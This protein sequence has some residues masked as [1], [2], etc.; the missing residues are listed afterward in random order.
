MAL[1]RAETAATATGTVTVTVTEMTVTEI[2]T[3][4]V[5]EIGA[6]FAAATA[7]GIVT[8]TGSGIAMGGVGVAFMTTGAR[9][10]I[11]RTHCAHANWRLQLTPVLLMLSFLLLLLPRVQAA[12]G[13][14]IFWPGACR[15]PLSTAT[16]Q[17]PASPLPC[18]LAFS[19]C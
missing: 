1:A 8:E 5:T 2:V 18:R 4:A 16:Q 11:P 6:G 12:K 14:R 17:P 13:R 10:R 19:E 15:P 3:V 7:T 9:T